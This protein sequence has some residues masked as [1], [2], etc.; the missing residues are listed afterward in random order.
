MKVPVL[1]RPFGEV[2]EEQPRFAITGVGPLSKREI[3][4]ETRA[5][6][7]LLSGP[8]GPKLEKTLR[9]LL[10]TSD[11]M[12][13]VTNLTG[14]AL[15]TS[16]EGAAVNVALGEME[17]DGY[18]L[19]RPPANPPPGLPAALA[20]HLDRSALDHA[21]GFRGYS[22][23]Y[24]VF[25][26]RS[27]AAFLDMAADGKLDAK[28]PTVNLT[29]A[30]QQDFIG[31]LFVHELL[32]RTTEP[33]LP[34]SD[35]RRINPTP[36]TAARESRAQF[37]EEGTVD[38]IANLPGVLGPAMKRMGFEHS[39]RKSF[40]DGY[41]PLVAAWRHVVT[42]AGLDPDDARDS[43][44]ITRLLQV[45]PEEGVID[46]AARAIIQH[47]KLSEDAFEPIRSS[48]SRI[49]SSGILAQDGAREAELETYV[50]DHSARFLE[51]VANLAASKH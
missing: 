40:A 21:N 23:P 8:L 7:E 11:A 44:A 42:Q 24:M 39:G 45:S 25:N 16:P 9:G 29:K 34:A 32:H 36:E 33:D 4:A 2:L 3:T 49:G 48:I 18:Q 13:G 15:S 20:A 50:S 14:I 31:S 12:S 41:T 46:E 1:G 6:Q 27:S 38:L 30:R 5:G 47:H 22:T 17:V 43:S 19:E 10:A 51:T 35:A 28:D 37:S 26:H